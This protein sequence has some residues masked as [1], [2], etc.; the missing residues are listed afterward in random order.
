MYYIYKIYVCA[1]VRAIRDISFGAHEAD[2]LGTACGSLCTQERIMRKLFPIRT[3]I[4]PPVRLHTLH[5]PTVTL[6]RFIFP[7]KQHRK[8]ICGKNIIVLRPERI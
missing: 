6:S 7:S 1:Y 4:P 3:S 5:S 8:L 2:S